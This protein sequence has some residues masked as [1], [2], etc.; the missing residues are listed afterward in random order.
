MLAEAAAVYTS[1]YKQPVFTY[2]HN[3]R[4]IPRDAWG[5]ISVL[6]SCEFSQEGYQ[7]PAQANDLGYAAALLIPMFP[8][9]PKVFRYGDA[10]V[11]VPG[12]LTVQTSTP[13]FRVGS[14]KSPKRKQ[15][16]DGRGRVL[17]PRP[18]IRRR[19]TLRQVAA[20]ER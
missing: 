12:N 8:T 20:D 16:F 10:T 13:S 7:E 4:S 2:T 5:S 18:V 11:S 14:T 6:A 3:W 1:K 17:N 9:S 19:K 15:I